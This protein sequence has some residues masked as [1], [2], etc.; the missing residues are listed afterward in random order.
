MKYWLWLSLIFFSPLALAQ[1]WEIAE[2]VVLNFADGQSQA[3][4]KEANDRLHQIVVNLDPSANWTVVTRPV[5]ITQTEKKTKDPKA[6]P[7]TIKK[8]HSIDLLLNNNFLLSLTEKDVPPSSNLE[9]LANEWTN[10]LNQFFQQPQNRRYLYLT[11]TLPPQ[12]TY[13][14]KIYKLV[15]DVI[16]D[17]GLFRTNGLQVNGRVIF[18]EVPANDRTY[19]FDSKTKQEIAKIAEDPDRIFIFHPKLQFV[20][21]VKTESSALK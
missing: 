15:T 2:Q 5:F 6:K 11:Q 16:P 4:I 10:K 7:T 9:T 17:R 18:W 20:A 1:P 13:K 8:L 3:R 14:G 21:Y 12:L 19:L